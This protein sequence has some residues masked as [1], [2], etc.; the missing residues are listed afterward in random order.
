MNIEFE[1][2]K[3]WKSKK[4]QYKILQVEHITLPTLPEIN[5]TFAKKILLKI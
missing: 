1:K 4:Y 2:Y 3:R 5:K